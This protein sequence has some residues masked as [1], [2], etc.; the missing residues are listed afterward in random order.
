MSHTP[1]KPRLAAADLLGVEVW[2]ESLQTLAALW[3]V[4]ALVALIGFGKAA[5]WLFEQRRLAR[6]GITDIDSM[7]G[8]TF[9]QRLVVLFRGLGYR[10]DHVGRRGDYGADLIVSKDGVRT[11]VQA[12]RW[13]RNVGPKAVQEAHA[14]PAMH[15][16]S[17]SMVVTNRYFTKAARQLARANGV[18]LWDRDRLV[19]ALLARS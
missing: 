12:K 19:A 15:D 8:R 9:E 18:E 6:C 5:L 17:R 14:A 10:V 3:P 1:I 13:T 11:V 7:D 16:C 2:I 4:W